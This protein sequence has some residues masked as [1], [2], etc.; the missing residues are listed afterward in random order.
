MFQATANDKQNHCETSSTGI[1]G[2]KRPEKLEL[3]SQQNHPFAVGFQRCFL[4]SSYL[5]APLIKVYGLLLFPPPK[6]LFCL[7]KRNA[8]KEKY[9]CQ[10]RVLSANLHQAVEFSTNGWCCNS[11]GFA[12]PRGKKKSSHKGWR[13]SSG[14]NL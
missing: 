4:N 13:L 6:I 5:H 1:K 3:P 9:R 8:L 11:F 10:N 12:N 14:G 2:K 7:R